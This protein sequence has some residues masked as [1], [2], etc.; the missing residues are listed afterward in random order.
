MTTSAEPVAVR[1]DDD[2]FIVDLDDGRTIGVPLAWFPRLFHASGKQRDNFYLSRA[3]LRTVVL[4]R[5]EIEEDLRDTYERL[6]ATK[7]EAVVSLISVLPFLP[8]L[9]ATS[10]RPECDARAYKAAH[11]RRPELLPYWEPGSPMSGGPDH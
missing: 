2:S 7:G 11:C 8:S 10:A 6:F 3:G 5:R 1:F 9:P 4:E